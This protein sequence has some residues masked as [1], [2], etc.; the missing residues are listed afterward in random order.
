[1]NRWHLL[2]LCAAVTLVGLGITAIGERSVNLAAFLVS[3]KVAAVVG[4]FI[5]VF[6]RWLW[7]LPMLHPWFVAAP[8]L[9]GKWKVEA[10][11]DFR[12]S[13]PGRGSYQGVMTIDQR[14]FS[15]A[16]RIDWDDHS[17]TTTLMRA[18][19]AVREEGS[20]AFPVLYDYVPHGEH[21]VAETRRAAYFFH[22]VERLPKR[23]S[24]FYSTANGQ[25]GCLEI[26]D[27]RSAFE[28]Q[29]SWQCLRE[30]FRK[31]FRMR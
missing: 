28:G 10:D 26:M 8:N 6:D 25:V 16:F 20:C 30:V 5:I 19:L 31:E 23:V 22:D 4:G 21:K 27:H 15:I 1:M 7:R 24:L 29:T 14:F 17:Y 2:A 9:N 12:N 18:P 11:I 3:S 13:N